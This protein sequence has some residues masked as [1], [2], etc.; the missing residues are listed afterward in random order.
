ML[1]LIER[2][3][4]YLVA[5]GVSGLVALAGLWVALEAGEQALEQLL[6]LP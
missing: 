1:D 4:R 3:G 2:T 5:V 6:Q